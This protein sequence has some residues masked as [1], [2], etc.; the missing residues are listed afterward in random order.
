MEKYIIEKDIPVV[1]V[2]A[3]SFPDGVM[4]AFEKLH[5]LTS[6]VTGRTIYGIFYMGEN[7]EIIYKAAATELQPNEA[8]KPGFE[9][10]TIRKGTYTGVLIKDF[11]SNISAVGKTFHELLKHPDLDPNGYCLEIYQEEKDVRC[12]VPLINQ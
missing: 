8:N 11:M 2:R 7:G 4:T 3:S 12:L 5:Q 10:F 6:S 9:S 1:C